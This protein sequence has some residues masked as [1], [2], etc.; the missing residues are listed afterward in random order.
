MGVCV[1]AP[2]GM[3][4]G[5]GVVVLVGV[6]RGGNHPKMLYYNIPSV[7]AGAGLADDH[8]NGSGHER[9]R[10]RRRGGTGQIWPA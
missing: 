6:G 8:R 3:G 10:N 4:V 2:M 5:M 9:E 1:V 7:H